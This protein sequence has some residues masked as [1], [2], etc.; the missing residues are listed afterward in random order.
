MTCGVKRSLSV[1]RCTIHF[2][3][4]ENILRQ[5]L[6]SYSYFFLLEYLEFCVI[7]YEYSDFCLNNEALNAQYAHFGHNKGC[8]NRISVSYWSKIIMTTYWRSPHLLICTLTYLYS[9][10][11]VIFY[12]NTCWTK[13]WTGPI[14]RPI[15][16]VYYFTLYIIKRGAL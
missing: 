14:R 3:R 2:S 1:R 13:C 10:H 5:I 9:R 11:L 12:V 7:K 6:S 15:I 4:A 16:V 8:P